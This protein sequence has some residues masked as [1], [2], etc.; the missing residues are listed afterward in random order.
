MRFSGRELSLIKYVKAYALIVGGPVKQIGC[1]S[2]YD[3]KLDLPLEG[4]AETVCSYT[5]KIP[6]KKWP[7]N[8]NRVIFL[9]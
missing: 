4:E 3:K 6:I 7:S 9:L 1:M 5:Q 2:E 8:D